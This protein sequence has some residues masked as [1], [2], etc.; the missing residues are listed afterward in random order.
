MPLPLF[1]DIRADDLII[2]SMHQDAAVL[3]CVPWNLPSAHGTAV[4]LRL[5]I[6]G[7]MLLINSIAA[8]DRPARKTS[9][10]MVAKIYTCPRHCYARKER[11]HPEIIK[12]ANPPIVIIR[13]Y[14]KCRRFILLE[15]DAV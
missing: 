11:K 2:Q 8:H 15:A 10:Q 3:G 5:F 1:H 12:I 6:A 9:I 13:I 4:F 7:N 14:D